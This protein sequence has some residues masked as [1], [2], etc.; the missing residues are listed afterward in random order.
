M[1]RKQRGG[2]PSIPTRAKV[3]PKE[4]V[5]LNPENGNLLIRSFVQEGPTTMLGRSVVFEIPPEVVV[6]AGARLV[7]IKG[8]VNDNVRNR[9][10]RVLDKLSEVA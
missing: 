8:G 5:M 9:L 1:A 2:R 7:D 4:K 10:R 3:Y 6:A